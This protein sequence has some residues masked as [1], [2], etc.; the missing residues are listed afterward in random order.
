M[1]KIGARKV[2]QMIIVFLVKSNKN[3]YL[4]YYYH[5][6]FFAFLFVYLCSDFDKKEYPVKKLRG[7]QDIY[8]Y[9]YI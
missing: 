1:E 9:I 5:S 7:K 2:Y 8:I 6:G 3:L 4:Y